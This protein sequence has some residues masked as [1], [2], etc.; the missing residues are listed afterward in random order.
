[1]IITTIIVFA[2]SQPCRDRLCDQTSAKGFSIYDIVANYFIFSFFY[3]FTT[4]GQ[5]GLN[6]FF[7]LTKEKLNFT[8]KN[9]L[10]IIL[11]FKTKG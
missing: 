4:E 7:F 2:V 8:C 10:S 9:S 6:L 3:N 1:M 11:V 5:L